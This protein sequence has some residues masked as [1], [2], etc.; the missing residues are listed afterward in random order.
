M[1]NDR[2]ELA[3]SLLNKVKTVE[4][5]IYWIEGYI[6]RYLPDV[7]WMGNL[8][9]NTSDLARIEDQLVEFIERESNDRIRTSPQE[10]S[11]SDDSIGGG[12]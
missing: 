11:S 3:K 7:G 12:V 9:R 2:I 4:R 10:D 1:S 8:S 6:A 5:K